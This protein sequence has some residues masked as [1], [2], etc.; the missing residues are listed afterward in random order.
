M[1]A[2]SNGHLGFIVF[3]NNVYMN[4]LYNGQAGL[5]HRARIP[6]FGNIQLADDYCCQTQTCKYTF[7]VKYGYF[8]VE[9]NVENQFIATHL[10]YAHRYY[11]RA[12]INQ[13]YIQRLGSKGESSGSSLINVII[14]SL[15]LSFT[16]ANQIFLPFRIVMGK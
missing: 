7:N 9:L 5:S 14:L 10:V 11:D 2:L 4:A 13:F 1:P 6:N 12:I 8:M 16:N 15:L 3:S